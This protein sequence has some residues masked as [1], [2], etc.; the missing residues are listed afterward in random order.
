MRN[1]LRNLSN[2][3]MM[4]TGARFGEGIY[5]SSNF[6]ISYDYTVRYNAG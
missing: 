2:T 4:T 3:L 5:A 6:S 1:G